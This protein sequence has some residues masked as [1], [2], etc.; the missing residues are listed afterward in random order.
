[1]L[2]VSQIQIVKFKNQRYIKRNITPGHQDY[3]S[4]ENL[5]SN[6]VTYCVVTALLHSNIAIKSCCNLLNTDRC[7]ITKVFQSKVKGCY[8][9]SAWLVSPCHSNKWIW[10]WTITTF[11]EPC[12]ERSTGEKTSGWKH[13]L[14]ARVV[15]SV[16]DEASQLPITAASWRCGSD[17]VSSAIS[18][19]NDR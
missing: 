8:S 19:F 7:M 11:V 15:L 10:T 5:L 12:S 16:W 3:L 17:G 18:D 4:W 9:H 6:Y 13:K 14:R 2:H 1:M